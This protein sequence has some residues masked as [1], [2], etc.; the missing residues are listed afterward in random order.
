MP[1][2]ALQLWPPRCSS[3]WA[4]EP[5]QG[6][7]PAPA[8]AVEAARRRRRRLQTSL[9]RRAR[10]QRVPLPDLQ[11]T[12]SGCTP[13]AAPAPATA[14]RL[15]RCPVHRRQR[16]A[17][18]TPPRA[19][20]ASPLSRPAC[21]RSV[22]WCWLRWETRGAPR[23]TGELQRGLQGR[24]SQERRVPAPTASTRE[25]TSPHPSPSHPAPPLPC[26]PTPP[27]CTAG[28]TS[29]QTLPLMW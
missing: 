18:G 24:A 28:W 27:P 16:L 12:T 5:R 4:W 7:A 1:G 15:C 19:Q 14:C 9:C 29:L 26:P 23:A 10:A 6:C 2:C 8:A 21:N 3:S 17:P 25:Q 22:T 13:A 11:L 20:R